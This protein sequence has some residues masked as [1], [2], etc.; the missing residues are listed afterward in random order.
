[1]KVENITVNWSNAN[2]VLKGNYI[3]D[4]STEATIHQIMKANPNIKPLEIQAILDTYR[5]T[6]TLQDN[7]ITSFTLV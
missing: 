2:K 1:M 7:N 3:W 5:V 6:I 4:F